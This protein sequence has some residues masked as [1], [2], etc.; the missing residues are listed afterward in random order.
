MKKIE[1]IIT[2]TVERYVT[3]DGKE[4]LLEKDALE[5]EARS[6]EEE[7]KKKYKYDTI[8]VNDTEYTVLFLNDLNDITKKEVLQLLTLVFQ[9]CRIINEEIKNKLEKIKTGYNLFETWNS[10]FDDYKLK[11]TTIEQVSEEI[12]RIIQEKQNELEILKKLKSEE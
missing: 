12:K 4:F 2:K 6:K 1:K 7:L 10:S 8:Y 5:Y 9:N 3:E 11:I